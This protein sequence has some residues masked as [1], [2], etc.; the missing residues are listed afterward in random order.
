M[1]V[2]SKSKGSVRLNEK[3]MRTWEK[4]IQKAK[5]KQQQQ[6]QQQSSNGAGASPSS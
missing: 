3:A 1:M 6:Q 2:E 5:E 4:R